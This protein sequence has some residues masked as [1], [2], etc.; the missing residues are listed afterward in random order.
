MTSLDE[1]ASVPSSRLR[2]FVRLILIALLVAVCAAIHLVHRLFGP[3]P[4]PRRL[5]RGIGWLAGARV[6]SDG[7]RPGA[8]TLIVANHVSWLDIPVLAG[9]TDC[10][11]V[12]KD[13]LRGHPFMRWLCEENGTVFVDRD[14]RS[15]VGEQVAAMEAAIRS[16]KP[17][18][19][20]PEGTVGDGRTLLPFRSSL[21]SLAEQ[22]PLPLTVQ[23]VAI[24]YG[25]HAPEFGWPTGEKGE[26]NFLRLLG[27]RG[28][29]AVTLH[30]LEAL[31]QG[32]DRKALARLSR[33]AV[34]DAIASGGAV[35][36]R[37]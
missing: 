17:L 36:P 5:L 13:S 37:V 19:L 32:L 2:A 8:G 21:L 22:P 26:A 15:S 4:W 25:R 9:A 34:A 14:T 20:F 10:A 30:F 16:H 11:F 7:P 3:S 33:A 1:A 29:V 27:R 28:T 24:D 12:A 31:P 23:P 6:R 35:P 18:T